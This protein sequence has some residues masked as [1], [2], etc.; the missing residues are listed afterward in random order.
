MYTI[1]LNFETN[2]RA[3]FQEFLDNRAGTDWPYSP[4]EVLEEN[5]AFACSNCGHSTMDHS[6]TLTPAPCFNKTCDCIMPDAEDGF[7]EEDYS[8]LTAQAEAVLT[9]LLDSYRQTL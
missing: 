5:A 1:G 6:W 3:E 7:T 2:L 8:T 9:P 4:E